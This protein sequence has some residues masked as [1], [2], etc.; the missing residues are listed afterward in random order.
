MAQEQSPLPD[1]TAS[2]DEIRYWQRQLL[3]GVLR[4]MVVFGAFMVAGALYS[5]YVRGNYWVIPVYLAVYLIVVVTA[6][7]PRVPY[8]VQVAIIL[9]LLYTLTVV[10]FI[11]RGLGDSSRI[12]LL[13]ILFVVGIFLDWKESIYAL[14]FALGT[15]V[16][17]GWL[18]SNGVITNYDEVVSTD[19]LS[20]INLTFELLGMGVFIVVSLNYLVPQIREALTRS[21][22]LTRELEK[23]QANLEEQ[24]AERTRSAELA[25]LEAEQARQSL[26]Q[27]LE[28]V[29][30][31]TQLNDILRSGQEIDDLANNVLSYIC[32]YLGAPVGLLYLFDDGVLRRAGQ[33]AVPVDFA[34]DE[35][36]HPGEG[37]V[38]QSVLE[39]RTIIVRDV[40]SEALK[41]NSGL[42]QAS[43]VTILIVPLIY[44]D[45]V[46]GVLELG[47]FDDDVEKKTV[48]L[49][50]V[51]ESIAVAFNAIRD[52][53]RIEHLLAETQRQAER[54]RSQEEELRTTNEEL[55]A[56]ADARNSGRD[57]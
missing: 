52:R 41:I 57:V 48:F 10:V 11:T 12:Y 27:Q 6:F 35:Q 53:L 34:Q 36:F 43:S 42:G 55:R 7:L 37:L 56:Q 1:D 18:F 45:E 26:E 49:E 40:S 14:L 51:A 24:V 32:R 39:K 3:R 17:F 8:R 50:K 15:M 5:G 25:R 2:S 16:V 20:W 29:S 30:A 44:G 21:R 31:Q 46:V 28:L 19:P 33:F 47:L 9:L 4:A 54:L 22:K 38:G 23:I 13:T